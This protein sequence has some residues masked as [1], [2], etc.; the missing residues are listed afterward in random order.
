MTMTSEFIID[1]GMEF[2]LNAPSDVIG[3]NDLM[4]RDRLSGAAINKIK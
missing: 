3:N 2:Y 1:H 4:T